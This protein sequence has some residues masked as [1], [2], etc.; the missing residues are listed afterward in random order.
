MSNL[1]RDIYA[2]SHTYLVFAMPTGADLVDARLP[3]RRRPWRA[4]LCGKAEPCRADLPAAS[5][6][7]LSSDGTLL[8]QATTGG[9]RGCV[10]LC[11]VCTFLTR[12]TLILAPFPGSTP[13]LFIVQCDKKLGSGATV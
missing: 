8:Q 9:G 2:C 5:E 13:Q 11:V 10:C 4:R 1:F 12:G 7:N 3:T 6:H